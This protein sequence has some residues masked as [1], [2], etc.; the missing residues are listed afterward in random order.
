MNKWYKS[1]AIK[2]WAAS[3][4]IR[5]IKKGGTDPINLKMTIKYLE[6][7]PYRKVFGAVCESRL[8]SVSQQQSD[9]GDLSYFFEQSQGNILLH[10]VMND[11][12]YSEPTMQQCAYRKMGGDL[13]RA[14]TLVEGAIDGHLIVKEC[15][16]A[17]NRKHIFLPTIRLVAAYERRIAQMIWEIE[18][19][20]GRDPNSHYAITEIIKYDALRKKHLPKYV[21]EQMSITLSDFTDVPTR[22]GPELN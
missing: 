4:A 8:I 12:Y 3:N 16:P 20:Q 19:R 15:L 5:Y 13:R 17:D 9:Y 21:S 14:R 7:E 22:R 2:N 6:A 11:F 1:I 10:L 18:I